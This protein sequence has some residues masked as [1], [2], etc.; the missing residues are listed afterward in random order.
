MTATATTEYFC[1]G[2]E[3][4]MGTPGR[5]TAGAPRSCNDNVACA[6]DRCDTAKDMCVFT[7]GDTSC[8]DTDMCNGVEACTASGCAPGTP[9]LCDDGV[10]CTLDIC[11]PAVGCAPV[12]DD[13]ACNDGNICTRGRCD[14]VTGRV[15]SPA[16]LAVRWSTRLFKGATTILPCDAWRQVSSTNAACGRM[17]YSC[18]VNATGKVGAVR[19]DSQGC[20]SEIAPPASTGCSV[21]TDG[22]RCCLL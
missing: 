15:S 9:L 18:G 14:T 6:I 19:A 13:K 1:N 17:D 3:K 22:F 16:E 2:V 4:C 12:P 8:D 10:A 21:L 20:L 5:C 11:D 7:R